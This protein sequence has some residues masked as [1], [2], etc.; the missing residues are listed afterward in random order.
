VKRFR[1][2]LEKVLTV[3]EIRRRLAEEGFLRSVVE[4]RKAEEHLSQAEGTCLRAQE[5]LRETLQGPVNPLTVKSLLAFR[6]YAAEVRAERKKMLEEKDQVVQ[7]KR[8]ELLTRTREKRALEKYKKK[9]L[10]DY[11]TQYFWEQGKVLD[12]IG[13]LRFARE[14]RR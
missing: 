6:D 5:D 11:R 7:V 10:D 8:G 4:R 1:F 12:E 13:T 14:E 3:K 2:T 9:K